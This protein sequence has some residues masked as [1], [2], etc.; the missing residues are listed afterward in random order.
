MNMSSVAQKP[1]RRLTANIRV[2]LAS[3]VLTL[4]AGEIILGYILWI[5]KYAGVSSTLYYAAG[6]MYSRAFS[7]RQW[8]VYSPRS[9]YVPDESLGYCD[10][11]GSY[12]I[13]LSART[14]TSR[15]FTTTINRRGNRITSFTPELFEGKKEIW[16]LGDSRAFGWG[17]NDE[18]TFPFLLQQF[19]PHFCIVNYADNGYGNVHAYLQLKKELENTSIRPEIA[20]VLYGWYFN[21]RNVAAPIRLKAFKEGDHVQ[22]VTVDPSAFRHPRASVVN[23]KLE[24]EYVPL[25][26]RFNNQSDDRNPS[27]EYQ[28]EVTKKILSEMYGLGRKNG[29]KMILAYID[30][31]DSD[32]VVSFSKKLGY[33]FCDIRPK[34]DRIEF[35]D[36]LPIDSHPGPLA[37]D[38]YA[39]KLYQT[40]LQIESETARR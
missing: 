10:L 30:G 18:T 5:C 40:I 9:P 24:I 20:V 34:P 17:N 31:S 37:Q 22:N 35:D 25:F 3:S 12:T 6:A 32:E 21:M 14:G 7:P 23:G 36:F 33:I 39:L 29:V 15:T 8:I 27:E 16:I 1:R 4:V 11:P 38:G 13:R 2:V 26:W 19:L 28:R